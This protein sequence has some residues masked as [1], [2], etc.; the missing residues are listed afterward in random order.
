MSNTYIRKSCRSWDNVG[1]KSV[2]TC[3]AQMTI[4]RMRAACWIPKVT[5]TRSECIT[6]IAFPLQQRLHERCSI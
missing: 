3:R 5:N 1:K 4:W 6:L 2:E